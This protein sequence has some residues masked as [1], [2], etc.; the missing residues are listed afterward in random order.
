MKKLQFK[1]KISTI[2]IILVLI[3]SAILVAL[4]AATAQEPGRKTTYP[5]IGATPNPVGLGQEVLLHVGITD[6][7]SSTELGWEGLTVTVTKPDGTTETLGPYRTDATG[8]TGAV[9]IPTMVGTYQLQTHFPEQVLEVGNRWIPAGTIY[10]SSDS[11]ILELEVL[12]DPI[13]YYPG[14]SLPTEYWTRPI[15]AQH[16]EWNTISGSWLESGCMVTT[17]P[18]RFPYRYAPFNDGPESAHILWTKPLTTGGLTGGSLGDHS[19]SV[20]DAYQGEF[21]S[22]VIINGILYYN[23]FWIGFAG[24]PVQQGIIALDLRTGEELWFKNNT[25]ILFG[26]LFY[27]DSYNNHGTQ[28]YIWGGT[29]HGAFAPVTNWDA[30]D[31]FTG[32][33]VYS[34]EG[35]PMGSRVYGPKGEIFIYS[36]NT[37]QARMT[38]WNSSRVVVDAGSWEPEGITY[39]DAA[40]L[41]L[42]WNVTI[43]QGLPGGINAVF[44]DRVIGSDVPGWTGVANDPITFWALSLEPGN[45]GQLL[46]KETWQPPTGNVSMLFAAYSQADELFVVTAKD[47]RNLYGFSSETGKQVWGPTLTQPYL[48]FY[49]MGEERALSRALVIAEG[50]VFSTGMGGVV[51]CF[52]ADTGQLIWDYIA[53]D[54]YSEILWSNN[55][56]MRIL[57]ITDGKVYLGSDEHS[58]INPLPRGSPFICLDMNNGNEIWKIDGAFR[59]TEWGGSAIIGDSI[60]AL[61]NSYDQRIYALGKGPTETTASIK[62]DVITLGSSALIQGKV[63]DMSTGVKDS[64]ITARFPRGVPAIS[65]EDMSEWMKY[66][67][68]QFERP[69]DAVGVTVKLE[70]IDPNGNYQYLGTATSDAYG[71]YG[72]AFEPEVKGTYMII[73]TFEGS[74]SYYGSTETTYLNVD[75]EPSPSTPIEPEQATEAPIISTEVAIIAAVAVAAV[76]GVAA[77][78]VLKKR[79]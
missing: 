66:V 32:E 14:S 20:G 67:Y 71:N 74:N 42:E 6:P 31:A 47:A 8:G 65:D 69:A 27:W 56:P 53:D 54:D 58:P 55:W 9:L 38:M 45:E 79:K 13:E 78:W 52:D 63:T 48:D 34:M 59:G 62:S 44:D 33:W 7:Q 60:I 35:V 5:F 19:M 68:M 15:D 37:A 46:Y 22:S 50:K 21:G 41:G 29:T 72:F 43:P 12:S 51:H 49:T 2:A 24:F 16:R 17:F 30:Y 1:T 57:I 61:Y 23:R 36:A 64:D 18:H 4:P 77:F 10:E 40:Q 11:E 75:P 25:R 3:I 73:A 26:Q 39:S 76:I 28:A 70:A